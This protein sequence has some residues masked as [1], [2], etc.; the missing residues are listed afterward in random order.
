MRFTHILRRHW[1]EYIA[2]N[3][4]A[5]KIPAVYWRAVEAVLSCR[6]ARLGG[7]VYSC[8][9]CKSERFAYHSCN[10]RACPQCGSSGQ[11]LWSARQ[12]ARRLPVPYFMLTFTVPEPLRWFFLRYDCVAYGLLFT[13]ASE[14]IKELFADPKH[15]GGQAGFTAVL[16]TWTRQMEFH[17][18]LHVLVPAVAIGESGTEVIRAK[19][20]EFLLPHAAL[21]RRYREQF[22]SRLRDKHPGLFKTIDPSL[23]STN[24]NI[25]IQSVGRGKRALRY[26][27]AYVK[28]SAF[29]EQRLAG[30]DENGRIRLWWRDSK[31]GKRKLMTLEASELIRRWLLHV[32]PKGLTRVRHYGFLSAAA[33]KS[34][35]RLR[36]LLGGKA[37]TVDLP[38]SEPP[39]CPCCGEAMQ[40][41]SKLLPVRGPPLS[42]AILDNQPC[43]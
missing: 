13:A 29:S 41:Q 20:P 35:R 5:T 40:L 39:I 15:F 8:Q 34:Y 17:P 11:Q 30:Y 31:D 3:G 2:R 7:H 42:R 18:H 33:V 43:Q 21:A 32:L 14:A 27:A 9:E 23:G 19:D 37:F 25:N 6:T 10:H 16:H 38:K 4:G 1:P 26:L 28:K 22:L 12:Q 24:W 36:F